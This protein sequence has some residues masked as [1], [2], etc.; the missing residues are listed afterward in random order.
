MKEIIS[1]VKNHK[2][3]KSV[4]EETIIEN[5]VDLIRILELPDLFEEKV[6]V[7]TVDKYKAALPDDFFDVIQVRTY[8]PEG[9]CIRPIYYRNTTD[10]FHMSDRKYPTQLT[11]KIQGKIIYT[12]NK[13]G[14]IEI[15]YKAIELDDCG[16]PLV[17][18]DA[19]FIRAAVAY[20]KMK[21]FEEYF[22]IGEI[23]PQVMSKAETDYYAAVAAC[24]TGFKMP[25]IDQA[26]SIIN[27]ANSLFIR[28]NQHQRGYADS[29]DKELLRI[30]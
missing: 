16:M 25:T 28:A 6:A 15:A 18:D 4:S 13:S 3:L 1:R 8:P 27:N 9:S 17:P 10:S 11:Y 7:L 29:G 12:S 5:V 2:M 20:V 14:D 22:D 30:H 24:E 21:R 23:S 19:R 26:E